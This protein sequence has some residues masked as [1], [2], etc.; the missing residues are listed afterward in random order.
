MSAK[1]EPLGTLCRI[2]LAAHIAFIGAAV[3][4]LSLC[5]D[6]QLGDLESALSR[7]FPSARADAF[8]S[9]NRLARAPFTV[10]SLCWVAFGGVFAILRQYKPLIALICGPLIAAAMITPFVE[11]SDPAWFSICAVILIGCFVGL[12]VSV[13]WC[14][15]IAFAHRQLTPVD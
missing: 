4:F 3:V 12:V 14:V 7:R 10:L 13:V 2:L 6:H 5:P 8:D 1:Q 15:V 9:V 11:F